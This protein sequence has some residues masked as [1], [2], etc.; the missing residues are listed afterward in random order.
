MR[1]QEE[2]TMPRRTTLSRRPAFPSTDPLAAV[3][4]QLVASASP[5]VRK[6]AAAIAEC[7]QG[8]ECV[9]AKAGEFTVAK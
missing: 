8:A 3:L 1:R 7:G 5:R 2:A 9:Q 4:R 6:W